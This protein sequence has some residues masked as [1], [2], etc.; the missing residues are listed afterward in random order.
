VDNVHF[1]DLIT[2]E[3]TYWWH[4]A[5]RL[6]VKK[7]LQEEFPPP[8][9][10]VEGGIGSSRNLI[11]F[12]ELGYEVSGFDLLPE[13]V[14]HGRSRGIADV[15]QHD[16]TVPWPLEPEST[17]A[18]VLLDVLE[19]MPD[20]VQ[21]LRNVKTILRPDG[22]VV[23]T[24]PAC[25]MLYG[26]WDQRLGHYRRYTV[27]ELRSHAVQ[28]GLKVRR[29]SY[30]NSF[31]FPAAVVVR[32][33]DRLLG[34]DAGSQFPRVSPTVNSLLLGC[35]AVER[36]WLQRLGVPFGLSIVGVLAK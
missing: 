29:I 32:G 7:V 3:D 14:E 31:T 21:V 33:M 34:R 26:S 2:L 35:A 5:K 25:P 22:G 16:L 12:R 18:V 4:V 8:G 28:A 36:W 1:E 13:V 15:R 17:R 23:L 9:R 27:K 20:P 30:W 10:L 11:E 24:V 6:L 19:H